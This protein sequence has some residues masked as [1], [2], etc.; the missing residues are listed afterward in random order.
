MSSTGSEGMLRVTCRRPDRRWGGRVGLVALLMAGALL[1]SVP[2]RPSCTWLRAESPALAE[3]VALSANAALPPAVLEGAI[4]LWSKCSNYGSGFPVFVAASEGAP[5]VHIE[6]LP[7]VVGANRCGSFAGRRIR[8]YRFVELPDGRIEI[9]GSVTQNLAHELGHALGLP[10]AARRSSCSLHIMAGIETE[11]AFSRIVNAE[12][13]Q[14]A[15][16]R[17]LTPGEMSMHVAQHGDRPTNY[18]VAG[19][20]AR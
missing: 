7:T 4:A 20:R 12:E 5:S 8:L 10:D 14:A 16:Q 17:W 2:T 19:G 6:Y 15:G 13:C 3:S 9:C 11:N 1:I 18:V